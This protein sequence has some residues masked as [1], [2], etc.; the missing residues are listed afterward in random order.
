VIV[1]LNLS[2]EYTRGVSLDK[3]LRHWRTALAAIDWPCQVVANVDDPLVYYAAS[4]APQLMGVSAG[5]L[6]AEDAVLCPACRATLIHS[7]EDWA[8]LACGLHR[9]APQ[10][11]LSGG[12]V[13]G[14]AGSAH[15]Q[16]A[17]TGRAARK[18]A[19]LAVA[20][21]A[22]LGVD[23]TSA[24]AAIAAVHDVDGRYAPFDVDGRLVHL[25]MVKNPAGWQEMINVAATHGAQMVF[26]MDA[27]GIKDTAV[28]WDAPAESLGRVPITVTG[29]RRYDLATWLSTCGARVR[30]GAIDPLTTI[31]ALPEGEVHVATNY[32]AFKSLRR[33]LATRAGEAQS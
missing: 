3:T 19:L 9:P 18:G 10:W 5:L 11:T 2:R 22:E 32:S 27:F 29:L 25:F 7:H 31:A 24:C 1:L 33:R 6:W 23:P 17:I 12:D 4:A 15:L 14:P 20:A 28:L 26:A 16:L 30:V 13:A 21:A 8:C